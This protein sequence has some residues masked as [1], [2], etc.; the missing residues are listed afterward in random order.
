LTQPANKTKPKPKKQPKTN[1]PIL[2]INAFLLS[3]NFLKQNT[4]AKYQKSKIKILNP[5]KYKQKFES[6]RNELTAN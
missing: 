3:E 4:S 1:P 5:T 2:Q 6:L